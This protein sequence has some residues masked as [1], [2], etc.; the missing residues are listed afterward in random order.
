MDVIGLIDMSA[1]PIIKSRN[2][3]R[4]QTLGGLRLFL[5]ETLNS[6]NVRLLLFLGKCSPVGCISTI[7]KSIPISLTI[8]YE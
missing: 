4:N 3:A 8:L 5:Y 1:D 2:C 6:P 7:T